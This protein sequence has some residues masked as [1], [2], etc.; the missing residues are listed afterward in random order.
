MIV[1]EFPAWLQ[2]ESATEALA[3]VVLGD[4]PAGD[5]LG[6]WQAYGPF[7]SA[8]RTLPA[9][10]RSTPHAEGDARLHRIAIPDPCY[11]SPELPFLYQLQPADCGRAM[12]GESSAVRWFG[13]LR[14]EIH[15]RSLRVEGRR[16]VWRGV[17]VAAVDERLLHAAR[18]ASA[19]LWAP[20]PGERLLAYAAEQ[21]V[22]LI[23]D[24]R[25]ATPNSATAGAAKPLS[26]LSWYPAVAA[27]VANRKQ[28]A[29]DPLAL[30]RPRGLLWAA[31]R[32][33]QDD[34]ADDELVGGPDLWAWDSV[35]PGEKPPDWV[36]STNRP[37][38]VLRRGAVAVA[39]AERRLACDALQAEFAPHGDFAGYFVE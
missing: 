35:Q 3:Q 2:T 18:A 6:P 31:P 4:G 24:V 14:Q 22:P 7:C 19:L 9:R 21:G 11:W 27:V 12:P 26:R 17:R 34:E 23:I 39:L 15:R 13:L 25:G 1:Q 28:V 33:S 30:R 16:T 37:V 5:A 38:L 32:R 8:A 10:Y 36:V 29:E 20:D